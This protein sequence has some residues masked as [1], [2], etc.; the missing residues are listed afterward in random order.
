MLHCWSQRNLLQEWFEIWNEVDEVGEVVRRTLRKMEHF[1]CP[2]FDVGL[3]FVFILIGEIY[4]PPLK[5]IK[6]HRKTFR[7][8]FQN[9]SKISWT[10]GSLNLVQLFPSVLKRKRKIMFETQPGEKIFTEKK[11]VIKFLK[12]CAVCKVEDN[13]SFIKFSFLFFLPLLCSSRNHEF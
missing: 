8:I 12:I 7:S 1:G 6:N 3:F 5:M 11:F 13:S 2:I 9:V 10:K 4:V